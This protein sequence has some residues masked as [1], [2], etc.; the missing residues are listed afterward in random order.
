MITGSWSNP[1]DFSLDSMFFITAF[2]LIIFIFKL[3]GLFGVF[4]YF[5]CSNLYI[6]F[7]AGGAE[8]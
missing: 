5:S 4:A 8:I 3:M 2:L 7:N 6:T 1:S